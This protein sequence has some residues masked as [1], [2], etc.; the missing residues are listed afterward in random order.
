[1]VQKEYSQTYDS[2]VG[3]VRLGMQGGG[4][5]EVGMQGGGGPEGRELL[6]GD[7]GGEE[8]EQG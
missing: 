4:G 7:R 5:P 2:R 8:R 3:L 1:M 6:R